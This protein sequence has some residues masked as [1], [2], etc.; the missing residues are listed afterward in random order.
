MTSVK[1]LFCSFFRKPDT[2]LMTQFSIQNIKLAFL[3]N[4]KKHL[5]LSTLISFVSRQ[6]IQDEE[7]VS[8][9]LNLLCLNLI[10]KSISELLEYPQ[11]VFQTNF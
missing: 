2:F 11:N 6:L 3:T 1:T 9:S 10:S 5:R 8:K 4:F 7:I